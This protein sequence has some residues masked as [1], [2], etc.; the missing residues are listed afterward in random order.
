[1]NAHHLSEKQQKAVR[2]LSRPE[3]YKL[4]HQQVAKTVG[5]D[6]RTLFT[7]RRKPEFQQAMRLAAQAAMPLV[8]QDIHRNLCGQAVQGD[9]QA[10][11]LV[12]KLYGQLDK[13]M[14]GNLWP[15]PTKQHTAQP[16]L[17]EPDPTA[18]KEALIQ[19]ALEEVLFFYEDQDNPP[20]PVPTQFSQ[21]PVFQPDPKDP[22]LKI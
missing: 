11:R 21:R 20:N 8:M 15:Y 16:D 5:V 22:K 18:K 7:W 14:E 9:L 10:I 1:M 19:S 3:D 4:T 2:L 13:H 17:S 12:L 6:R